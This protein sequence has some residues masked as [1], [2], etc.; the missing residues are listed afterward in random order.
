[1]RVPVRV[2]HVLLE[3][4]ELVCSPLDGIH[5]REPQGAEVR[6]HGV[7]RVALCVLVLVGGDEFRSDFLL[8]V[9]K[10]KTEDTGERLPCPQ[11]HRQVRVPG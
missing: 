1:M 8:C 9:R 2:A 6:V 5:G 7:N 3:D 10:I 4:A 11:G